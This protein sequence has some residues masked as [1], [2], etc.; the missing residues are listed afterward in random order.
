[1]I[2]NWYEEFL[3]WTPRNNR[4]GPL[5]KI[6]SSITSQERLRELSAWDQDGGVLIMSYDIFRNWIHNREIKGRGR[7]LEDS[8]HQ[9]VREQLLDGPRIVVADEAHK[10]KNRAAGIATAASGFHSKSRIALTG[11]P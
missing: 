11:S 5:R 6:T 10:M 2:E 4:L 7:P 8:L 3:M 1:L 9:T